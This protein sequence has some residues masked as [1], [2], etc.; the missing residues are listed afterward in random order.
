MPNFGT[1]YKAV[2][3]A[4]Q[5]RFGNAEH[6]LICLAGFT[7]LVETI[8]NIPRGHAVQWQAIKSLL[9]VAI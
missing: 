2:R 5:E 1:L 9:V 3:M 6:A 8:L 4:R 7:S